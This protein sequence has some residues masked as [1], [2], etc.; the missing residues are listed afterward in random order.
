MEA[1]QRRFGNEG[2]RVCDDVAAF[3][4]AQKNMHRPRAQAEGC[5][6]RDGGRVRRAEFHFPDVVVDVVGFA[7]A[8]V[9]GKSEVERVAGS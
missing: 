9:R 6:E 2:V 1:T 4:K 7:Q 8:G 3:G 5:V